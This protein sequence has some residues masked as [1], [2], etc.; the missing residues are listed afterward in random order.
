M[1]RLQLVFRLVSADSLNLHI[2]KVVK[3]FDALFG[4]P[5]VQNSPV[6]Q[7]LQE[8]ESECHPSDSVFMFRRKIGKSRA[9]PVELG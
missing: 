7:A 5:L 8:G 1:R 4:V 3:K 6:C 2:Q 9:G